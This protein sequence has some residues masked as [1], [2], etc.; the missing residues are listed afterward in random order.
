MEKDTFKKIGLFFL[1]LILAVT[2][3]RDEEEK[4]NVVINEVCSNN[5]S[6]Q[7]DEEGNYPDCIEL[8]NRGEETVS[9]DGC[10]LTDDE[11]KLEKYPLEGVSV[12]G[13]GFAVI[14]LSED[15]GLRISKEGEEIFLTDGGRGDFLDQVAVPALSYDTSYGRVQDG[16]G[17]WSVMSA[18]LG[19]SNEEAEI[20]P[21]TV[22]EKPVFE[23]ES[24]FYEEPFTLR[25]NAPGGGKIY[26]TLDG[27]EPD[28]DSLLYEKPLWIADNSQEENR[29]AG[30]EDLSPTSDYAP[31]FPVDKAVVVRAVSYDPAMNRISPVATE[32]FFIGYGKK[33]EYDG[34]AVLS[35]TADPEDLFDLKSGMYG[36]GIKYEEYLAEGGMEKGIILDSYT[37][38]DGG[39]HH[40]YMAS[41]AYGRGREWEKRASI[42]YFDETH[43]FCF[44]QDAGI[45]IAGNSTRGM[46]QKSF[47]IF[48]RDIYDESA[49]LPYSFFDDGSFYSSVKIRNG[50]GKAA[51]LKFL[52]AFLEEAAG[53]RDSVSVQRS[54]PCVV[55]LNG[56]YWGIYNIR[57]RYDEE[58]VGTRFQIDPDKVMLVKAGNAATDLEGTAEAYQYMLDVITECDLVYEDTYAL[59][60]GLADMQ[61]LI[62]Y[63]CINLY[64]DNRDVAFGYNTAMWR[65]VQEGTPYSD[66]K[67]RFMIYDLDECA[68]PDSNRWD[69]RE[70][71]ME[72]NALFSEPAVR[73]LLDNEGF[74]RQFC[75]SFMDIANTVFSYGRIHPMLEEWAGRYG[76]QVV[77]DHQCFF[78][79]TYGMEDFEREV[80]EL[81]SFFA[82]RFDF[83]MKSLAAAFGLSGEL[84]RVDISVNRPEGG[85]VRINTASLGKCG[86]W[87]GY[88]YSDYP[89]SVSAH[90]EEGYHFAGWQGDAQGTEEEI[91]IPL[92]NGDVAIQAIFEKDE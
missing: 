23:T 25:L 15:S 26:Y 32:V 55:F 81:D 54:K 69:G 58:Y 1:I 64:L 82:G 41:N 62:D 14:F 66:G 45:R 70:K 24:G 9:L 61:S 31:G 44:S 27:S 2:G 57:E 59:A 46:P 30:R 92:E 85:T 20:R 33:E 72:E 90:A 13:G 42:S 21:E 28:G 86:R 79:G 88:Y 6:A 11:K 77:K 47:H 18:T 10:F 71:W 36:N 53:C 49:V 12:P 87:E 43:S 8:Y 37:D 17:S 7:R 5:F 73:S 38:A 22:L 83:A 29:Y 60:S 89:V 35:L 67:W 65:S 40:R 4:Q 63:C 74:R 3:L 52:D 75:I 80:A 48:A 78:D 39:V 56:E 16:T 19:R 68:H 51:G 76:V 34:M 91:S 84:T 50:G